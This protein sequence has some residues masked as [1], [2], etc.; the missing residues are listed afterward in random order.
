VRKPKGKKS[1]KG[2]KP[3]KLKKGKKQEPAS[4]IN[5]IPIESIRIVEDSGEVGLVTDY[6]LAVYSTVKEWADLRAYIQV[7]GSRLH[8]KV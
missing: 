3:K 8:M 2:K 4:T 5:E 6:L 7:S 1:K